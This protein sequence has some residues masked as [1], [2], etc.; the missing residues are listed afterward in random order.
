M[1]TKLF[2]RIGL[3]IGTS[4]AFMLLSPKWL[5]PPAAWAAPFL[6]IFL[7]ADLTPW[8]SY[9]IAVLTL[10]ISSLVSQHKVMP[11]PGIF[12][13]LMAFVI[14]L[15]AAIPYLLN[16]LLYP[17]ISGLTKTLI[18]PFSLVAF[19]YTSSFG[20]GGSWSSIAYTQVSNSLLIQATSIGGIWVITFSIGWF[21][22]LWFWITEVQWKWQT[23]RPVAIWFMATMA[24]IMFYGLVKTNSIFYPKQNTV[25]VAGLTNNQVPLLQVIYEDTFGKKMPVDEDALTQNSPELA[26]LQKGF[27]AFVEDPYDE[28]FKRTHLKLVASQDKLLALS[29]NE[30]QAG[31]QIVS[32]SEAAVFTIKD[33]EEK[34]LTKGAELA[35][36]NGI[37][38]LMTVASIRPGKIEFG[39]KFIENKAVLFDPDGNSLNVF[40]K[41]R[42]VPLIEPSVAGD[43]DVPVIRTPYGKLAISICYDADFPQLMSQLGKKGA[44]ILL[45]PSGDWKE[46]SP[47]HAQMAIVRAIENGTSL[48]RP[49]SGAVSIA[50]DYNGNIVARRN[51]FDKGDRV[52]VAYLPTAGIKTLYSRVGDSF[53][54]VCVVGLVFIIAS[55]GFQYAKRRTAITS[56]R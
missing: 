34:L 40:F 27:A 55:L 4:L 9:A 54:W 13:P 47:Y 1:K 12:F 25:R 43:G 45:L 2:R 39:K 44:D 24:A 15:Q 48:L 36:D 18:F 35:R 56:T 30:A 17:K 11:F 32:W 7:I 53:A 6:L 16:R 26:E 23:L 10:F 29:R 5:F 21:A 19:E 51:Y 38:F 49:V 8:R 46:V 37:Y 50:C 22:S 28:K 14:S 52:V 41:N 42:P 33:D 20:G 3:L 31:S